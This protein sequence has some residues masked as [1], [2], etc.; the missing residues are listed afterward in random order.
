MVQPRLQSP[1][2][3]SFARTLQIAPDQCGKV[4]VHIK[5]RRIPQTLFAPMDNAVYFQVGDGGELA[6]HFDALA[7]FVVAVIEK[8]RQDNT[9]REEDENQEKGIGGAG[10]RCDIRAGRPGRGGGQRQQGGPEG[11]EGHTGQGG[12]G[13]EGAAVKHRHAVEIGQR[14]GGAGG[15]GAAGQPPGEVGRPPPLVRRWQRQ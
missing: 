1:P 5:N 6:L 12:R 8:S 11:H 9:R 15:A 4:R 14:E 2:R 7:Y 3:L 10:G 13:N